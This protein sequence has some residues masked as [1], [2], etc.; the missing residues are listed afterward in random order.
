MFLES[1]R[2]FGSITEQ[3]LGM[4]GLPGA[5][6]LRRPITFAL[7]QIITASHWALVPKAVRLLFVGLGLRH[8]MAFLIY[9]SI[10]VPNVKGETISCFQVLYL[11]LVRIHKRTG[12]SKDL[13]GHFVHLE[14]STAVCQNFIG[15]VTDSGRDWAEASGFLHTAWAHYWER[16][17]VHHEVLI[18]FQVR[19]PKVILNQLSMCL[20]SINL[21]ILYL[22]MRLPLPIPVQISH[23][24]FL[25]RWAQYP[26]ASTLGGY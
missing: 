14:V 20:L 6:N 15:F 8:M 17:L 26:L 10:Q 13:L 7:H 22:N 21:L 1:L 23:H 5:S 11:L 12:W 25:L 4:C 9:V 3:H 24:K 2:L 16:R 18:T 19:W